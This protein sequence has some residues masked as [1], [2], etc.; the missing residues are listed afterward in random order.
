MNNLRLQ[1]LLLFLNL[2]TRPVIS[3]W[4]Y[5]WPQGK[6][7][8]FTSCQDC[9]VE[10]AYDK[11]NIRRPC[12]WC[13]GKSGCEMMNHYTGRCSEGDTYRTTC[14]IR[15]ENMP[16]CVYFQY[17]FWVNW[18]SAPQHRNQC[19]ETYANEFAKKLTH[20]SKLPCILYKYILQHFFQLFLTVYHPLPR[21][22]IILVTQR[23]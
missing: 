21:T 14:P 20:N 15:A 3:W 7:P 6:C 23:S 11:Y 10:F 4:L 5:T 8:S 22:Y 2:Y 9:V 16:R 1:L 17:S 18:F 19:H 12:T 13:P